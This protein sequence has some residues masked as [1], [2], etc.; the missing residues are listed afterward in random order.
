MAREKE[1]TPAEEW[2]ENTK[3]RDWHR[4]LV[5]S[6]S[7]FLVAYRPLFAVFLSLNGLNYFQPE[8][9]DLEF[10]LEKIINNK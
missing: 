2:R 4:S 7:Q 9:F 10:M 1:K 3:T 6:F 5:S 8:E